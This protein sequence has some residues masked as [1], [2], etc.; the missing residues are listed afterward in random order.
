MDAFAVSVANG[1]QEPDMKRGRRRAIA[2]TFAAFQFLMPMLGWFCVSVAV[3]LFRF[4]E[5]LIPWIALGLLL[6][7]GGKMILEARKSATEACP[8][9]G[10]PGETA[11]KKGDSLFLQGVATSIDALS[12]GFT[13]AGYRLEAAL[14]SSGIIGLVTYLICFSGVTAGKKVGEKTAEKAPVLGGVIL[15][16]IGIEIAVRSLL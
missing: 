11:E 7:I 8:G 12:V 1:L 4:I 13:I 2:G 15:I 14:V 6:W 9:A 3:E 5:K 10:D 16:L